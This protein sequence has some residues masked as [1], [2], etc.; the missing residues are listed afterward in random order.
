MRKEALSWPQLIL[1]RTLDLVEDSLQGSAAA[2]SGRQG[3]GYYLNN[4]GSRNKHRVVVIGSGWAAHAFIKSL[5]ATSYDVTLVS[6]RNYFLF[7]PMLAGAAT[8]TVELRSITESIRQANPDV[9]YLEATVTDVLTA[10]KKV[11]IYSSIM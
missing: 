7:T 4:D 9:N 1:D 11:S 2:K 5:D 10:D 8:G 6:P 3:S